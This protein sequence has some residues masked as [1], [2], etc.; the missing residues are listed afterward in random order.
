MPGMIDTSATLLDKVRDLSDAAAWT[1][2][3]ALYRPVVLDYA[4][5]Q[6]LNA[7]DAEDVV[8]DVF[9]KLLREMPE[10][11]Y[12]RARGRFRGWLYRITWTTMKDCY[13]RIDEDAERRRAYGL[14]LKAGL[15]SSQR[16]DDEAWRRLYRDR[17]VAVAL[18]KVR[19][20]SKPGH[21]AIFE[22]QTLEGVPAAA[23]A[24]EFGTSPTNVYTI[25]SRLRAGICAVCEAYGEDLSDD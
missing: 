24:D 2:F 15:M 22:R 23:V 14:W 12:D 18:A 25:A 7:H 16:L 3:V 20:D 10:F 21:W 19:A 1:E 5:H 9:A 4:R 17:V 11:R 8:Q 6:K 13:R